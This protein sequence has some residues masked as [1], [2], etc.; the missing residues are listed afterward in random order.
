[1]VHARW[2]AG[3]LKSVACHERKATVTLRPQ[4]DGAVREAAIECGLAGIVQY[5]FEQ[6][7]CRIAA[8]VEPLR[9]AGGR[10]VKATMTN[11]RRI[12]GPR[13]SGG[14]PVFLSWVPSSGILLTA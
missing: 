10:V 4:S 12:G 6:L 7:Q 14:D 1:M 3:S 13:L 9:C 5:G 8:E 2:C 11:E